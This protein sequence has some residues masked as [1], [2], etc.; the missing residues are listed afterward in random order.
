M[1][2][3][4]PHSLYQGIISIN[5]KG[6]GYI[7]HPDFQESVVVEHANLQTALH[8]DMVSFELFAQK[9]GRELTGKVLEVLVRSKKG[10]AG[11]LEEQ[12]GM[13]FVVPQDKKMYTDICIPKEKLGGATPG[14]KVFATMT[15]WKDAKKSPFGVIDEVLG[16]PGNN[17]VEM[18]SIALEKGF[19]KGFPEEVEAAAKHL[20]DEGIGEAQMVGRRDFRKVHTCTIDPF[21]AKD[22]DDAL[23]F[24]KLP[25]GNY[26]IGVH[27]ADV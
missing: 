6:V 9:P 18:R 21:D 13:Y 11:I 7:K 5:S 14:Q 20:Y 15:D 8:G 26:E 16:A 10:F 25:N 3:H 12:N 27:I 22:F 17:D 1:T 4:E 24:E 2:T 23:S 19:G